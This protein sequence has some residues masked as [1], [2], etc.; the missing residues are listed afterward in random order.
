MSGDPGVE[1]RLLELVETH[2]DGE[3]SDSEARE[4]RGLVKR[5]TALRERFV[6]EVRW[7]IRLGDRLRTPAIPL[8]ERVEAMLDAEGHSPRIADAV[9]A[10]ITPSR[11]QPDQHA[12]SPSPPP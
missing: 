5:D 3:L 9:A 1:E 4:L 10:S 7:H 2:L 8:G 11:A 6:A 12:F